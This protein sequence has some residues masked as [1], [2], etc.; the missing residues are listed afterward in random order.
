MN[1][2]VFYGGSFPSILQEF[3][4][5]MTTVKN[6]VMTTAMVLAVIFALRQTTFGKTLTTKALAS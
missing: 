4:M 6:A 1:G 2:M 3:A 5:N